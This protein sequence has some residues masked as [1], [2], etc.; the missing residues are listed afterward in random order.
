MSSPTPQ[1]KPARPAG[2]GSAQAAGD[3]SKFRW[4][5][6]FSQRRAGEQILAH[7][8][9]ADEDGFEPDPA[10]DALG[11]GDGL[12]IVAGNRHAN[13]AARTMGDLTHPPVADPIEGPNDAR[14]RQQLGAGQPGPALLA[15]PL[16]Q[17]V[18]VAPGNRIADVHDQL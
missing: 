8:E 12:R 4:R 13:R 14:T 11:E 7:R 2:L 10:D 6:L 3:L 18:T 5:V 15:D 9:A 16:D 17:V 1:G